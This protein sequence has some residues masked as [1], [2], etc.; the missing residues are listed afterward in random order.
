MTRHAKLIESVRR[1]HAAFRLKSA[2]PETRGGA[3]RAEAGARAWPR[4]P[5]HCARCGLT[6]DEA[7][8]L[9]ERVLVLAGCCPRCDGE[10]T[11]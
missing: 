5:L 4:E 7:T 11:T 1:E 8:F 9:Q 3:V 10:L 2:R 6:V